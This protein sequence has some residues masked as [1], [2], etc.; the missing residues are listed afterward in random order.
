ML[1]PT[2]G[3]QESEEI[4]PM[5]EREIDIIAAHGYFDDDGPL[6]MPQAIKKARDKY[7][8]DYVIEHTSPLSRMQKSGEALAT[9]RTVQAALPLMELDPTIADN[10]NWDEYV[11]IMKEA[12]GAP[13]RLMRSKEEKTAIREGRQQQ[14][15]QAAAAQVAPGIAGAIK[16]IAQA[17]SFQ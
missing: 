10:F 11:S 5:I 15:A 7:P 16:D 12:N 8:D 4:G 17:Q 6:P 1:A 14:Q 2:G 3:R 13:A 9:E